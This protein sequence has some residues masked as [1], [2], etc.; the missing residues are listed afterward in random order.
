MEI[1]WLSYEDFGAKGDGVTD[2]ID[3]IIACHN[4]ANKTGAC[5]RAKDGAK[6]Y[7]GP[8]P[9][10]AF[11][12]TT[13][14]FG[15][16]EFTIDDREVKL[17]ERGAA[18]FKIVSDFKPYP[19]SISS[20]SKDTKRL[21]FEHE[22]RVFVKVMNDNHKMFIRRSLNRNN[23]VSTRDAFIVDA[24]GN[25]LTDIDWNFETVTSATAKSIEDEPI[26]IVGGIFTTVANRAE[27]FYNYHNR[28]IS[29][30]R[31]NVTIVDLTHYVT[32]E[33]EHGAPYGGFIVASEVAN[34]TMENCVMTPHFIYWTAS[35]IPGKTVAMG[36]Y[37][38]NIG[39]V[40]GARFLSV[41][42]TVNIKD[43]RYW[44]IFTSN[45]CKDVYFENCILSRF[46]AHQGVTNV[47][48][49]SCTFG[50]QCI[51]LIGHGEA[52][53]ENCRIYGQR[54]SDFRF[55][56]GSIWD[57]NVTVRNC[58]LTPTA[59]WQKISLFTAVNSG[60]HDF[61]YECSLPKH[62]T[63]DGL[64]IMNGGVPSTEFCVLPDYDTNNFPLPEGDT[65]E[66]KPF[67]Y[68]PTHKLTI[69]NVSFET[70][71]ELNI[72]F[73]PELYEGLIIER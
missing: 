15:K 54:I 57:G 62:I 63:I 24:E 23:G 6:Y 45:F 28:G 5:V 65:A 1:K 67:P 33:G 18:I 22:G 55:D 61:G 34:F 53:I 71:K 48:L 25:I 56:Y 4:E 59:E 47:T 2:D 44:G 20:L 66:G 27:S 46:D 38:I 17:G 12:K 40:I 37:D 36:S 13:T 73:N 32:G 11:I 50:H 21:D 41:S 60:D 42:Q 39:S 35:Q 19:I 31:S 64:K 70:E 10:T 9:K 29:V 30:E 8:A 43:N 68:E 14:V 49:K 69:R 3:A 51:N 52:L 7:I 26:K 16:A 58:V 72:T